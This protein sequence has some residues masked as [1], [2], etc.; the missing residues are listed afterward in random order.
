MRKTMFLLLAVFAVLLASLP[1]NWHSQV[2]TS[3]LLA[4]D[5]KGGVGA[6]RV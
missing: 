5:A 6:I 1:T 2:A 3:T 4:D